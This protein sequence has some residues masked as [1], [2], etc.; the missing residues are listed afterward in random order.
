MYAIVKAEKGSYDSDI[1][2]ETIGRFS[3]RPLADEA[4]INLLVDELLLIMND[5]DLSKYLCKYSSEEDLREEIKDD[6]KNNFINKKETF[7]NLSEDSI[8][9]SYNKRKSLTSF[10]CSCSSL[11]EYAGQ[12]I[13]IISFQ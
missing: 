1:K 7:I 12:T 11:K 6:I 9:L 10:I 13:S 2:V 4:L 3:K 8:K 5:S